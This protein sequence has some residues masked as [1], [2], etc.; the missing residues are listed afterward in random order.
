[1]SER[2]RVYVC[3]CACAR[4]RMRARARARAGVSVLVRVRVY[5]H[6]RAGTRVRMRVSPCVQLCEVA[7]LLE[8]RGA[9]GMT[10]K[11]AHTT[12]YLPAMPRRN[13]R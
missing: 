8:W 10:A 4:V 1:M 13:A 7:G 2:A 5:T 3:V 12:R 11:S 6:V 9:E